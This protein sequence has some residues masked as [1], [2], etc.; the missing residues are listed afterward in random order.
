[1]VNYTWGAIACI[2]ILFLCVVTIWGI[3][4]IAGHLPIRRLKK[5]A[6]ELRRATEHFAN[7]TRNAPDPNDYIEP[8]DDIEFFDFWIDDE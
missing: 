5:S 3:V 8:F 2:L 7:I 1:M 6:E 4:L